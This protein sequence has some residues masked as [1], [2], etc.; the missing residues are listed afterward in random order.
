MK[1]GSKQSSIASWI[2]VTALLALPL[3]VSGCKGKSG[4]SGITVN[5]DGVDTGITGDTISGESG[6]TSGSATTCDATKGGQLYDSKG[7]AN[8]HGV[9]AAST[10]TGATYQRMKDGIANY[11]AMQ[12][13]ASLTDDEIYDIMFALGDSNGCEKPVSSPVADSGTG[14]PS[15]SS[16]GGS[17]DQ[18]T[19]GISD[20]TGLTG[21]LPGTDGL[22]GGLP[23]TG[24]LTDV[25]PGAD[26]LTGLLPGVGGIL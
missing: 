14:T 23:G 2:I 4:S 13:Y 12:Q 9:L 3:A 21:V 18:T 19:T 1:I 6:G 10:K 20:P 8:C 16:S 22:T 15:D 11:A 25:L 5:S 26:E 17:S 24:D 7:C